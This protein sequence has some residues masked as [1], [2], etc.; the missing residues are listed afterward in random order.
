[1]CQVAF[2]DRV[3]IGMAK[4]LESVPAEIQKGLPTKQAETGDLHGLAML[5]ILPIYIAVA[6]VHCCIGSTLAIAKV[7]KSWKFQ[8]TSANNKSN[9][10]LQHASMPT[11][12]RRSI[13]MRFTSS[14]LASLKLQASVIKSHSA[15]NYTVVHYCEAFSSGFNG[16]NV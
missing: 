14:C 12:R 6:K 1:M 16:L 9:T 5:K 2:D 10:W 15:H 8:T 3:R 7:A 11:Y 4:M 13:G